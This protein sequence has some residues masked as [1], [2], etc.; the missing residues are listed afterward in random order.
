MKAKI[1]Q[2]WASMTWT[3]RRLCEVIFLL[4]ELAVIVTII[5]LRIT[6]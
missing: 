2:K 3:E 5:N 6:L 4:L 1:L